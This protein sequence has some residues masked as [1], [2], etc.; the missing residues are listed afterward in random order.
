MNSINPKHVRYL[1][2]KSDSQ[3]NLVSKVRLLLECIHFQSVITDDINSK[4]SGIRKFSA[5]FKDIYFFKQIAFS[6]FIVFFYLHFDRRVD[7][8]LL[9]LLL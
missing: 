2:N 8:R 6:L 5:I 4:Q 1:E 9:A 7:I 3:E